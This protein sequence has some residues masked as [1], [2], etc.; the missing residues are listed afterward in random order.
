MEKEIK[1]LKVE[2]QILSK[3]IAYLE[4]KENRR[5]IFSMIRFLINF[6]IIII[7]GLLIYQYYQKIIDIYNQ[8]EKFDLSSSF[9]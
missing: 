6:V 4:K 8:I 2:I 3:R 1:N 9:L 5:K 7:I